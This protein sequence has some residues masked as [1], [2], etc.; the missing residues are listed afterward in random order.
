MGGLF[1]TSANHRRRRS[2]AKN[3]PVP[4]VQFRKTLRAVRASLPLPIRVRSQHELSCGSI[5][6]RPGVVP[7]WLIQHQEENR[8]DCH[9]EKVHRQEHALLPNGT[10]P[11][12]EVIVPLP[13]HP[14]KKIERISQIAE[15]PNEYPKIQRVLQ[16]EPSH[17][18][19]AKFSSSDS[20]LP[21]F[22]LP[23]SCLLLPRRYPECPK[24][25]VDRQQKNDH[26]TGRCSQEVDRQ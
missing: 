18:Q 2:P 10:T 24:E 9:R 20:Q 12:A 3:R 8:S 16:C 26:G 11:L 13:P 14:M 17:R 21:E 25:V 5:P 23:T 4:P 6:R 22:C 15:E 1:G 19:S 7:T